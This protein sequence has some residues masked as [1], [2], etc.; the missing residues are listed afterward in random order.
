MG[1]KIQQ[2]P[3][4]RADSRG[5]FSAAGRKNECTVTTDF[6]SPLLV[7]GNRLLSDAESLDTIVQKNLILYHFF[8]RLPSIIARFQ[9]GVNNRVLSFYEVK[10][11]TFN[12]VKGAGFYEVIVSGFYEAIAGAFHRV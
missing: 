10:G 9:K 12:E 1:A 2:F 6:L 5:I 4:I 3:D 8:M 11:G 7:D